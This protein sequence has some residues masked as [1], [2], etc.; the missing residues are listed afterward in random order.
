MKIRLL[1]LLAFVAVALGRSSAAPATVNLT[2]RPAEMTVGSGSLTLKKGLKV[3]YEA[4]LPAAMKAEVDKFVGA[5][6]AATALDAKA[7]KGKG[8]ITVALDPT[9]APEG[10]ALTVGPKGA[11]LKASAPA[12]LFYGFQTVK[13]LLP[14]NVMAGVKGAKDEK[15]SLP[16]VTIADEPRFG[17]RGFMLDVSRH[18]FDVDEVKKMIDLMAM[19]K[20][21]RFHW[22]LTDD[23]GWRM[24]VDKYPKLTGEGATNRNI[25]RTDFDLQKQ[26]REGLDTPYGP[27][28]YT[29]DEL[30]D[31][32]AYAKE[33]HIEII[34]EIDMPGHMVAAIHAYPEFSTDPDRTIAIEA[35]IDMDSEPQAGN[36]ESHFTH[37][38]WNN[39]GVSRDVLDISNPK[40]MEFVMDVVDAMAEIFPYEYIHIGGDECPT[41]AWERSESCKELKDKV[42]AEAGID[43]DDFSFRAL[44]SWFT[45]QVGNYAR[46]RHGKKLMGW[47]ELITA[48]GANMPMLMPLEP[49]IFCWVGA[50]AA[51]DKAQQ[52]GLPHIYT[53][54]DGG[55]Y[56]NRCY[57]GFDKVGAVGD[58]SISLSYNT[59]PPTT[60]NLI[61][62]QAT[63]WTEQVDRDRDLEYQTLPRLLA[64]AEHGWTP[65]ALIDYENFMERACADTTLFNLAG[66]NYARH[67]MVNPSAVPLPDPDQWYR[68][69]STAAGDRSGLVWEV[70]TE[71]SPVIAEKGEAG[72]QAGRLWGLPSADMNDAQLF[73]F[74]EDPSAPGRYAIIC[75][76]MPSGSLS[77]EP[78]AAGAAGRWDYQP[79]TVTYGFVLDRT[80]GMKTDGSMRLAIRP[81]SDTKS[82]INLARE[83][84]GH[85]FNIYR[86]PGEGS[87]GI[88]LFTPAN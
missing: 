66:L 63:F 88:F 87:G 8:L 3:G 53:P 22:H 11:T 57:Q 27:Y 31:V 81:A 51:A 42:A 18:F 48:G 37:N 68:L 6:N 50:E 7:T 35:G 59:L 56:I 55:Y 70:L 77:P 5:L 52:L 25:L 33:R 69:G 49:V 61:G 86:N 54:H 39:G 2:P 34:P 73:R 72:A 45:N 24:P 12:G 74:V 14:A 21:N 83:T 75:K 19:Y 1:L 58:G 80:R 76:A 84:Q 26:W 30:K 43:P 44:Q 62:V 40:V 20:M 9:I 46:E 4:S 32:V 15:Y 85:A 60:D 65:A 16:E 38:I 36:V 47:N 41:W 29:K 79:S 82:Y 17:Y 10:Y 67:Q 78:S 13:M 64:I 28:A 71:D 23:Q